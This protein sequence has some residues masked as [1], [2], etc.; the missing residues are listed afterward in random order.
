MSKSYLKK[1][2]V[3]ESLEKRFKY[4]AVT[5]PTLC[6]SDINIIIAQRME[7]RAIYEASKL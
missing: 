5:Q 7:K 3:K 6:N 1:Q 2:Q 4:R